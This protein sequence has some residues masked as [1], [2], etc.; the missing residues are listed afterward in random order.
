MLKQLLTSVHLW[1]AF[2]VQLVINRFRSL[3]NS[4]NRQAKTFI[5]SI[6]DNFTNDNG[7]LVRSDEPVEVTFQKR[8]D[9]EDYVS[10]LNLAKKFDLDTDKI[11]KSMWTNNVITH[12]LIDE[13]LTEIHDVDW[14]LSQCLEKVPDNIALLK[15]LLDFGIKSASTT[16]A[17][18]D[19]NESEKDERLE[20]YL[21]K[22]SLFTQ[23]L[24]VYEEIL[25]RKKAVDTSASFDVNFYIE[26]REKDAFEQSISYSNQ[27]DTIALEVFLKYEF[28]ELKEHLLEVLSNFPETLSP[29]N[30]ESIISLLFTSQYKELYST[31]FLTDWFAKRALQ[32]LDD[33]S[34][35]ENSLQLLELGINNDLAL[36][37]LYVELDL[38]SVLL[39]DNNTSLIDFE[40]FQAMSIVDKLIQVLDKKEIVFVIESI[41]EKFITKLYKYDSSGKHM[42]TKK[43]LL[44]EYLVSMAKHNNLM[45]CLKIFEIC[46]V[47]NRTLEDVKNLTIITDSCDLIELAIDCI[48]SYESPEE[49]DIA[50][51]IMECLPERS[52]ASVLIDPNDHDQLQRF[53]QLNDQADKTEYLLSLVEVLHSYNTKI[54]IKDLNQIITG[55]KP[56]LLLFIENVCDN[57]VSSD[58]NNV[59]L[60]IEWKNFFCNLK[61]LNGQC[62]EPIEESEL[63]ET[64]I[65]TL[66]FTANPD[67]IS[68]ALSYINPSQNNNSKKKLDFV[69][70][71]KLVK[72]AAQEYIKFANP[73]QNDNLDHAK[74]CLQFYKAD[75]I[76]SE[77]KAELEFIQGLKRLYSEFDVQMLPIK[78]KH[79]PQPRLTIIEDLLKLDKKAY[80]K[81]S[82]ILEISTLLGVCKEFTEDEREGNILLLVGK[83]ALRYSDL[84]FAWG[85]CQ[86]VLDKN[87]KA[88]SELCY[89]LA[90]NKSADQKAV[91]TPRDRLHLLSFA[92]AH[93]SDSQMDE[94]YQM[95][96]TIKQL[97]HDH[98]ESPE[99]IHFKGD[100]NLLSQLKQCEM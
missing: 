91:V 7:K 61:D 43:D 75:Q 36:K 81:C 50:F 26:F 66:L 44:K 95:L 59:D 6:I 54:T 89:L 9:E 11:Y 57:F 94:M 100:A 47:V 35:V 98:P 30:Y 45:Q 73:H 88:S 84:P 63:L 15:H 78:I 38:Y 70:G 51:R 12:K 48:H 19:N 4:N 74:Q 24:N 85:V 42:I 55:P 49:I 99:I 67:F 71:S 58:L 18:N 22:F 17:A 87:L 76:D 62:D 3:T 96:S 23:R 34:L 82:A 60:L 21:Q 8:I 10:A 69:S 64:C 28:D 33:T 97:R 93:C 83:Q 53:N 56:A 32:I 92:L 65:K 40:Q 80:K 41:F 16:V 46:T 79:S 77:V 39:Y 37:D 90:C 14:V 13:C 52:Q 68:I 31:H 5:G 29:V 86:I 25:N 2:Y 20:K 27:A 72:Q 1:I